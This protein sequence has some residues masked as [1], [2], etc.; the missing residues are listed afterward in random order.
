[1]QIIAVEKKSVAGRARLA[2]GDLLV[3]MD[4]TPVDSRETLSRLVAEKKWGDSARLSVRRGGETL[5]VTAYFR[6][7]ATEVEPPAPGPPKQ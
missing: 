6:R 4:G 3:S 2:V 5:D 1:M 7:V